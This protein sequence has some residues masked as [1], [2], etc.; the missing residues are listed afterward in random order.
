[1][2]GLQVATREI[3]DAFNN[4]TLRALDFRVDEDKID[5]AS[6]A[7]VVAFQTW[8]YAGDPQAILSFADGRI[9]SID[10]GD[11]FRDLPSGPLT[12]VVIPPLYAIDRHHLDRRIVREAVRRVESLAPEA[13]LNAICGIPEGGAW[14]MPIA[15]RAKVYGWLERRKAG[16]RGALGTWMPLQA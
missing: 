13:I 5:W 8:I 15:R 14:R 10:H 16:V 9:Y 11:C 1:M 6:W 12:G 7:T 2:I 4:A 3:P